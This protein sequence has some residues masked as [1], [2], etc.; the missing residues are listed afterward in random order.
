MNDVTIPDEQPVPRCFHM[1]A[2]DD[3]A[4]GQLLV[5]M[6]QLPTEFDKRSPAHVVARFIRDNW[7]QI[8]AVAAHEAQLSERLAA[9]TPQEARSLVLPAGLV[10]GGSSVIQIDGAGVASQG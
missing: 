5:E 9:S 2:V 4:T 7:E 1:T 6:R 10:S 3:L 8:V